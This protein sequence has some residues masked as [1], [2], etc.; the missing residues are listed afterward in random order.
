M[1]FQY[2]V[3]PC[4]K[5][6]PFTVGVMGPLPMTTPLGLNDSIAGSGYLMVNDRLLEA[7]PPG[8]RVVTDMDTMPTEATS[9]AEI[10]AVSCVLL[11]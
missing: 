5:L 2:T 6:L 8:E 1:L 11:T 7:P 10:A 9:L 3:D 4:T